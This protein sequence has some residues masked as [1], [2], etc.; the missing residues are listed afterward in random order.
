VLLNAAP[1]VRDFE[2]HRLLLFT[3]I[4]CVNED[5]V[6]KTQNNYETYIFQL[7]QIQA[8]F[9]SECRISKIADAMYVLGTLLTDYP[10]LSLV[11]ITMGS[12]GCAFCQR[13]AS[14]ELVSAPR[15][16]VVDSTVSFR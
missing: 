8:E 6:F 4:L 13:G 2:R 14:P 15:V 3:D 5:E 10:N 12:Q 1:I 11:I 16:V 9:L 7:F